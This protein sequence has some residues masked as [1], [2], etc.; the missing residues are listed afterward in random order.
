MEVLGLGVKSELQMQAYTTARA[1]HHVPSVFS[2]RRRHW[3]GPACSAWSLGS[4]HKQR[5]TGRWHRLLPF[6]GPW[7][8]VMSSRRI[9]KLTENLAVAAV[10]WVSS[11]GVESNRDFERCSIAMPSFDV[12]VIVGGACS[13]TLVGVDHDRL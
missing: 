3:A 9:C 5:P 11:Q 8:V 7:A 12:I 2:G 4:Q 1:E 13:G 10:M 6:S